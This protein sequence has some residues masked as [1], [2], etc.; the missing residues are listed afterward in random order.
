MVQRI[1]VSS[2]QK[3][4][5]E[6]RRSL[7]D[8][9]RGDALL[10][11]FFE[12]FLFEELPAS[13]RRADEIYLDEVRRCAVYVGIFGDEYGAEDAD[14]LSPTEREF[15]EA[16]SA[17]KVRLV[18]VKGADDGGRQEKMR[19]LIGKAG[20]QVV[21]RRFASVTELR[22]GLYKALVQLLEDREL[23]RTGPFDAAACRDATLA[24]L[25]EEEIRRF[26]GVARRVRGF[27]LDE[28]T[29][30]V[31]ILEHLQILR[32][33]LPTHAAVLLFGKKPQRFLISSEV[34]CAHFHGTTRTKP[35]PFYRTFKGTSFE[36]T[37]QAVDFVLSKINVAVGTREKSTQAPVA[38]EMPS[39]VVR[40][41]I[42][43][44]I[45]HR[46]Y[47]SKA[48]VQVMLFSDRLEVWNPGAL[49][50]TLTLEQLRQPHG[51]YPMNPLLAE[52]LYLAGYIERMGTG[53]GDMIRRCRD[54][55]LEEPVFALNDGFV[56][57][58]R[59]KPESAFEAVGGATGE[60]APEVT[61]ED[62]PEVTPEVARLL[63]VL[64]GQMSRVSLQ[65]AL[66][67]KD[68]E[69]FRK[70]YLIPAL[71]DGLI[72]MTIPD[73]PTSR[74][75]KYRLTD[76]GRKLQVVLKGRKE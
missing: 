32:G 68:T 36:T 23:I 30:P 55:G 1:F 25:S 39:E 41:A 28:S 12:V 63:P 4:L 42:V 22:T 9:V 17:G 62:A 76:E 59:R 71:A 75:Q 10:S 31:E 19:A 40:E 24:D 44:A 13:D 21:R 29:S 50:P 65:D 20:S 47:T 73:K 34:K 38:Y 15:E 66:G 58:I 46:D 56:V 70:A 33:G 11:R 35:I 6:E 18:F 26:V 53:T 14:G 45:A 60:V 61:P 64:S 2:V 48:S 43:N 49:P 3:E 54:A 74:F 7:R 52:P 16:T 69:H 27:P 57:T 5:A 8:F 51:S 72:E 37:D 67:L